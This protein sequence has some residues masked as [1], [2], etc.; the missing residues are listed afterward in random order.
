MRKLLYILSA[1]ASLSLSSCDSGFEEMNMDPN[2]PTTVPLENLLTQ[3]EYALSTRTW[4][5][6]MNA[7]WGMLLV[8][9][10][11]QNQYASESRYVYDKAYFATSWASYYA[12]SLK[13][14]TE[15][16]RILNLEEPATD[17]LKAE[18]DNKLAIVKILKTHAFHIVT[19][20]WGDVPYSEALKG[21]DIAAP[22][23][24]SQANIY[25]GLVADLDA[26]VGM[27]DLNHKAFS[28]GDIIYDND[29][30]MWIKF[31]NSLKAKIALRMLDANPNASSILTEALGD[32]LISSNAETAKF[33]FDSQ[34][35]T[36][37]PLWFNVTQDNRDDYSVSKFF[38]D[39]LKATNDPRLEKYATVNAAGE[40]VGLEF[41]L[42]DNNS[43]DASK[44]GQTSRPSGATKTSPALLG[45]R[46]QQQPAILM[47]YAEV[48][49]IEAEAI[50]RGEISGDAE[51]VLIEAITASM[52]AWEVDAADRDAYLASFTYDAGN[53]RKSI[54]EAKYVALYGQGVEAWSEWRRL[55][56]PVLTLP[57]EAQLDAIP[58]RGFYPD[59]EEGLNADNVPEN[60]IDGKVWWDVNDAMVAQP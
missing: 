46:G 59:E 2:S 42:L 52:D 7:E 34:V 23:Y 24:D 17:Q 26:A 6:V 53:W 28:S 4:G 15:I 50:A 12:N 36:G 33:T 3:G 56:Y 57:T 44:D 11:S 16:E 20:V 58:T 13:D 35:D 39:Y 9:Y 60:K 21:A 43:L 30:S 38:V 8:Q 25:E 14:F 5:T 41:G 45:V 10:W 18:K 49:F 37:N 40:Y 22:K 32:E 31:A 1:A 47:S 27:I 54:G 55:D 29:L 48:K 51:A 19:D